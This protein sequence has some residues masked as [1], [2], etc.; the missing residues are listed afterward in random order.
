MP[1]AHAG[2]CAVVADKEQMAARIIEPTQLHAAAQRVQPHGHAVVFFPCLAQLHA[3]ALSAYGQRQRQI[4]RVHGGYKL[5]GHGAQ[6]GEIIPIIGHAVPG[7]QAFQ[8]IQGIGQAGE[9]RVRIQQPQLP[10]C[11]QR[12][13]IHAD[14][15]GRCAHGSSARG[16]QLHIVRRQMMR[17]R[18]YVFQEELQGIGGD[19]AQRGLLTATERCLLCAGTIQPA[20]QQRLSKPDRTQREPRPEYAPCR[21]KEHECAGQHGG[22]IQPQRV[23]IALLGLGGGSPLQ[24]LL[25]ADAHTPQCAQDCIQPGDGHHGQQKQRAQL[26]GRAKRQQRND[27]GQP[28]ALHGAENQRNQARCRHKRAAQVIQNLEPG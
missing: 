5:A 14:V 22:K 10:R 2:V 17:A 7:A 27:K 21:G 20:G 23:Q 24:Q 19:A 26:R 25:M 4:A 28:R 13:Q 6:G 16:R 11:A 8:D 12:Q 9:Q 18:V 15:G 3:R 1:F